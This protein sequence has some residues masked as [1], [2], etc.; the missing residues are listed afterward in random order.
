VYGEGP[1]KGADGHPRHG[2]QNP[3]FET[4]SNDQNLNDRNGT[5]GIF[6]AGSK[7]AVLNIRKFEFRI[8]LGFRASNFEFMVD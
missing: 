4:I 6:I 7:A 5:K 3:N 2:Y 8:C 1:C